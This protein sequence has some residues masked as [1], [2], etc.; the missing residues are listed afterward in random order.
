MT[1]DKETMKKVQEMLSV[2]LIAQLAD[3]DNLTDK[4]FATIREMAYRFSQGQATN[5]DWLEAMELL[6]PYNTEIEEV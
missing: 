1:P 3:A 5:E 4:E 6:I 2:A